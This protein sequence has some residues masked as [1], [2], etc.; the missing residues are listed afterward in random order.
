M[1]KKPKDRHFGCT[2]W[3]NRG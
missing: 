2:R 3:G 1:S